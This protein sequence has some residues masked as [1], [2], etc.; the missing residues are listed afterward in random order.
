MAAR[1]TN[2]SSKKLVADREKK[3]EREKLAECLL[4][5]EAPTH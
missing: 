1:G 5:C 4:L 3:Q 2:K